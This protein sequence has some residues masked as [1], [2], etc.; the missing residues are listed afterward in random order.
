MRNKSEDEILTKVTCTFITNGTI[1]SDPCPDSLN[2]MCS[3]DYSSYEALRTSYAEA[4]IGGS[5]GLSTG[6]IIGIAVGCGVAGLLLVA[7][8]A[9][10]LLR[11]RNARRAQQGIP[12]EVVEDSY[13]KPTGTAGATIIAASA[14]SVAPAGPPPPV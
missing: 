6:A 9:W 11:R 12:G 5:S 13:T 14:S 10:M 7:L 4:D 3:L 1:S 2:G 8:C